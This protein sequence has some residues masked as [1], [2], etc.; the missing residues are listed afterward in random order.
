[1]VVLLGLVADLAAGAHPAPD[2]PP[3]SISVSP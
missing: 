2:T 3:A 1:V